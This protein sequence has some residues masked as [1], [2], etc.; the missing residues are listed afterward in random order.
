M[1][2]FAYDHGNKVLQAAALVVRGWRFHQATMTRDFVP[3]AEGSALALDALIWASL[4][5]VILT[6][7]PINST[8]VR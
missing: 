2:M 6:S 8:S 5:A 7:I 4:H 3:R 1:R